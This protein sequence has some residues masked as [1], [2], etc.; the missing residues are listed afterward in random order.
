M[1]TLYTIAL[2]ISV[3]FALP[4]F[5]MDHMV[6]A[7]D[8]MEVATDTDQENRDLMQLADAAEHV[9]GQK[10]LDYWRTV[11]KDAL[12][13]AEPAP[14]ARR[15]AVE[16]S[17]RLLQQTKAL[18]HENLHNLR[19][20]IRA[21]FELANN[22][23]SLARLK[24]AGDEIQAIYTDLQRQTSHP[25]FLKLKRELNNP[26]LTARIKKCIAFTDLLSRGNAMVAR[27]PGPR[28]V[29]IDECRNLI[30]IFHNEF[31]NCHELNDA[32][33]QMLRTRFLEKYHRYTH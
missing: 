9:S 15:I 19:Q 33:K 20:D 26:A 28:D 21:F 23:A 7:E 2:P 12:D 25:E 17:N 18:A 31:A 24:K 10:N 6:I 13:N 16:T 1:K 29:L 8:P 14:P 3:L 32:I 11:A 27:E 22:R 5:C 30:R 4:L